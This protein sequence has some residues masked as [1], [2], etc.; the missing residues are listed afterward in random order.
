MQKKLSLVHVMGGLLVIGIAH[1]SQLSAQS[2][3][4]YHKAA[5][6]D[7]IRSS[8]NPPG[9]VSVVSRVSAAH[10]E[11]YDDLARR[12]W[13][14]ALGLPKELNN[15]NVTFDCDSQGKTQSGKVWFLFGIIGPAELYCAIPKDRS[16]FFPII[17][18]ECSNQEPDPYDGSTP[19][20]AVACAKAWND[21]V[22][23]L[24]VVIDGAPINDLWSYRVRTPNLAVK[25][26][27]DNIFNVPKNTHLAAAADGYYLFV[28]P[29]APG[30]HI[31]DIKGSTIKHGTGEPFS[32]NTRWN[33]YV[34]H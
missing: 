22:S 21:D 27:E 13:E 25:L 7:R 31:I 32:I 20:L 6:L 33:L 10:D 9:P 14:W 28:E 1:Q 16:L 23:A 34:G 30:P 29:L 18:A 17:N 19:A 12:W 15:P 24:S 3:P 4:T 11:T 2:K 5:V 8:S 26:P